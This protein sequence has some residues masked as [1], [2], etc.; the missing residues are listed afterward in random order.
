MCS[1]G[2][3]LEIESG[4]AWGKWR[5][6]PPFL[7]SDVSWLELEGG[8]EGGGGVGDLTVA[9]VWRRGKELCWSGGVMVAL[10]PPAQA[11]LF[12]VV[13]RQRN[14]WTHARCPRWLAARPADTHGR[15]AAVTARVR[16]CGGSQW[17]IPLVAWFYDS[18]LLCSG[19]QVE[20]HAEQPEASCWC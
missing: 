14:L 10:L 13:I 20:V 5:R 11:A 16:A 15:D 18:P 6:R 9:V 3:R 7:G 12:L 8:R 19:L 1:N 2:S 4:R 17:R